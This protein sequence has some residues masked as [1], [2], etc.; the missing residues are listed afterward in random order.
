MKSP[1]RF[2]WDILLE[3]DPANPPVV[4]ERPQEMPSEMVPREER[5]QEELVV[6]EEQTMI[7]PTPIK[8]KVQAE[9]Q[10][11]TER[12]QEYSQQLETPQGR[13]QPGA[14]I[15]QGNLTPQGLLNGFVLAEL[16][17]KPKALRHRYRFNR[18]R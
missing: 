10:R 7:L 3:K 2:D 13:P 8:P 6:L 17:N 15:L 16:L 18:Y 5:K 1:E 4:R 9:Q 11:E 12:L 14:G